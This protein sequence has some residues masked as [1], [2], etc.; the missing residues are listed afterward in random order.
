[1]IKK[2]NI[3][4]VLT[5]LL[6]VTPIET[7]EAEYKKL[8]SYDPKY[9]IRLKVDDEF[10]EP[11]PSLVSALEGYR[12]E[13]LDAAKLSGV[14]PRAIAGA[15]LTENTLNVN[16][17]D[18]AQNFLVS[19]GLAKDG[20]F[21]GKSFSYGFGQINCARAM[22]VEKRAMQIYSRPERSQEEI[23]Q[24]LLDPKESIK[25]IGVIIRDAVDTYKENGIDISGDIGVQTTLY[26]LGGVEVTLKI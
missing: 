21:L 18:K 26:N 5:L 13:M 20:K 12:Q 3:F 4:L 9:C 7:L 15:I 1:M 25:Y 14:D 22:D 17:K 8:C 16:L 6:S 19:V 11:E 23:C 24:S 2:I 10:R